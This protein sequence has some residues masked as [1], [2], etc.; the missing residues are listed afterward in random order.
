MRHF[1]R[2]IRFL[3]IIIAISCNTKSVE[4]IDLIGNWYS[5]NSEYGY[6]ELAIDTNEISVFSHY[7]GNSGIQPYTYYND[8]LNYI[9]SDY[10]VGVKI[11]SN[12]TIVLSINSMSDTLFALPNDIVA[13]NRTHS[14]NDSLFALFYIDFELRARN[15]LDLQGYKNFHIIENSL[16]DMNEIEEEEIIIN[17]K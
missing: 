9:H 5:F 13:F 1:V 3:L 14:Q 12:T 7:I 10:S 8:S 6:I 16:F 4:R 2:N 15:I 11:L 17:R